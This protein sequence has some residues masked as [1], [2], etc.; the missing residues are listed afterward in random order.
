MAS[1]W[2]SNKQEIFKAG[3][4]RTLS[5][6]VRIEETQ[7][8]RGWYTKT[9]FAQGVKGFIIEPNSGLSFKDGGEDIKIKFD[10]NVAI[11]VAYA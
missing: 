11:E 5:G 9:D 7:G 8:V 4:E 6:V 2:T 10:G 3:E 1:T